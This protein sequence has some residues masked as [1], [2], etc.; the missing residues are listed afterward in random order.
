MAKKYSHINELLAGYFSGNLTAEQTD[1]VDAWVAASEENRRYLTSMQDIWFSSLAADMSRYDSEKAY[2]RFLNR[3][4]AID[5]KTKKPEVK[6]LVWKIAVA[7][8]TLFLVSYISFKQGNRHFENAL[9]DIVIEAPWGSTTKT[10]LPDGTLAWLNAGTTIT[11]SQGFG[12]K[13][14][15]VRLSGEGYFEVAR[16]ERLPFNVLTEETSV[17]VLGTKFNFRN[18]SDDNE[19]EISLLEGLILINNIHTGENVRIHPDRRVIIDKKNG[20]MLVSKINADNTA[21]WINGYVFFDEELL[22]DIVKKLERSYH[23]K[24]I[25][26]TPEM[27]QLR[28][29]GNFIRKKQ[30]INDILDAMASTGKLKYHIQNSEIILSP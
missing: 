12:I 9:T 30:S 10:F 24:I 13:E 3:K 21:E 20:K 29:Y 17:R 16:N 1:E 26:K 4:T 2:G 8:A 7:V 5:R 23:V 22:G 18:Y 28:F 19:A 14:R 27:K 25:M 11:Y 6:S 15:D